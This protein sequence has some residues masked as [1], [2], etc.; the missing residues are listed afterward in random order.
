MP[1]TALPL[2]VGTRTVDITAGRSLTPGV[3]VVRLTQAHRSV[4]TR[5]SVVR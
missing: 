1:D 3:Y 2:R 5:V 4:V